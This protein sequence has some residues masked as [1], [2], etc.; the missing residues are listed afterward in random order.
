[1]RIDADR[2]FTVLFLRDDSISIRERALERLHREDLWRLEVCGSEYDEIIL[3]VLP[4][5]GIVQN[6]NA[7]MFRKC[8]DCP[9]GDVRMDE[10]LR[11]LLGVWE[12]IWKF[13]LIQFI[14]PRHAYEDM[15]IGCFDCLILHVEM[16][17]IIATF[18]LR[19]ECGGSELHAREQAH[20]SLS[21]LNLVSVNVIGSPILNSPASA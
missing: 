21:S 18:V 20:A 14:S 4:E 9:C 2:E 12:N 8:L 1:M 5:L 10:G 7:T 19:A 13:F 17:Y 11:W 6:R 16:G 3:G 15:T